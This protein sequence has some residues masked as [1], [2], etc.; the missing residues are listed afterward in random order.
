MRFWTLLIRAPCIITLHSISEFSMTAS[1]P[2][3]EKGPLQDPEKRYSIHK[4]APTYEEIL[5]VTKILETGI[6]V[7]DLLAPYPK[8]GKVYIREERYVKKSKYEAPVKETEIISFNSMWEAIRSQDHEI[9]WYAGELKRS[10][11]ANKFNTLIYLL[12]NYRG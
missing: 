5:P 8:G 9:E 12:T 3:D 6:K 7:I 1:S 2:I 11:I 10:G 4:P